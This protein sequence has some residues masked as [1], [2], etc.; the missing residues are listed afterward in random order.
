MILEKAGKYEEAL[1][2]LRDGS[3]GISVLLLIVFMLLHKSQVL[4][5]PLPVTSIYKT[6]CNSKYLFE[7]IF[8]DSL[9]CI[10]F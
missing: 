4:F 8:A 1:S 10:H 6:T 3:E 7:H 5:L 9:S 2:I